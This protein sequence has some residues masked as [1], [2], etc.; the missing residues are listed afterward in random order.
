MDDRSW[1]PA[2]YMTPD[3]MNAGKLIGMITAQHAGLMQWNA[4]LYVVDGL[5][6]RWIMI[7]SHST[8]TSI[9]VIHKFLLRDPRYADERQKVEFDR[10][11][12]DITRIGGLLLVETKLP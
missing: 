10:S 9:T 5:V 7:G 8:S 2:D 4:H 6:Y 3:A 11:S 1:L 12:D